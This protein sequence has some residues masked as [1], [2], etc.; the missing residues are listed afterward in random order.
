MRP[1]VFSSQSSKLRVQGGTV[2]KKR[3]ATSGLCVAVSEDVRAIR[4]LIDRVVRTGELPLSGNDSPRVREAL[5][6]REDTWPRGRRR[7]EVGRRAIDWCRRLG[8]R[9]PRPTRPQRTQARTQRVTRSERREAKHEKHPKTKRGTQVKTA[10]SAK[11][12]CPS[13]PIYEQL[14]HR[15][16]RCLL[17]YIL[18]AT[19]HPRSRCCHPSYTYGG[20]HPPY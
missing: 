1:S 16:A 10:Q 11:S 9:H 4:Q 15:G 20:Y 18:T 19:G 5:Q 17:A 6:E 7:E 8:R 3:R 2:G 13:P 12:P 14:I